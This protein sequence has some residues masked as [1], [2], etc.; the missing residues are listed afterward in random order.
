ML[1]IEILNLHVHLLKLLVFVCLLFLT[2]HQHKVTDF[3][4]IQ[5]EVIGTGNLAQTMM[6][7]RVL[8]LVLYRTIR[9]HIVF[10]LLSASI[11]SDPHY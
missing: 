11:A 2:L 1:A 8:Q 3:I 6:K 7:G 4:L 5:I 10:A 9:Y